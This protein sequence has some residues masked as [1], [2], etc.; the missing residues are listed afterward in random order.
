MKTI[1]LLVLVL[2]ATLLP[3]RGAVAEVLLCA[4]HAGHS[5]AAADHA[6]HAAVAAPDC[7]PA[8][9]TLAATRAR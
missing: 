1:R 3:F 4:G 6:S 7:E 5:A 8:A 9:A 2:L